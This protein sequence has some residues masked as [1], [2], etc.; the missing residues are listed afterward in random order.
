MRPTN[1]PVLIKK[2]G[3]KGW[4]NVG[5]APEALILMRISGPDGSDVE[6]VMP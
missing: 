6:M 4:K 5:P 3:E 1:I 2:P